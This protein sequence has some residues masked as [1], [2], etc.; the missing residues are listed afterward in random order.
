MNQD[1]AG[2]DCG[3]SCL[4]SC[5]ELEQEQM[6]DSFSQLN[7]LAEPIIAEILDQYVLKVIVENLGESEV[8]DLRLVADKWSIEPQFIQSIVPGMSEQRE[9]VLSLPARTDETFVDIQVVQNDAVIAIQTV[10]VTLSV[11]PFSVKIGKD[12]DTGRTYETIIVDNTNNALRTLRIDVTVNK[13]K[14]TYLIDTGKTYEVGENQVLEQVDYLYQ[15]LPAGKYE[16]KSAFF[17]N[18]QKIGEATSYVTLEGDKKTF[19]FTYLF[20]FL[21][22]VI[23]GI[24]CYVFFMSQKK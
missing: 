22:L 1:E 8:N 10:P 9:L 24:S 19:N 16:V 5:P 4:T 2:I 13:G 17:E 11:P 14:E 3:G 18:G 6:V 12:V 15:D 21:L 7:I 23:V 20:Y